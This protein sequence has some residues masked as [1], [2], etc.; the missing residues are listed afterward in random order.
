[1]RAAVA[2]VPGR[3]RLM[4]RACLLAAATVA[5][6]AL[7]GCG[8]EERASAPPGTDLTIVLLPGGRDKPGRQ[9]WTLRCDPP[10]GSLPDPGAACDALAAAA[11][12]FAPV[13]PDTVCT[14]IFGGYQILDV[15]G[16]FR[17]K[18]IRATFSRTDGCQIDRF[19]R[20]A[21]ALGLRDAARSS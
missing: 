6:L 2:A 14:Q 5:T 9:A 12:P 11:D 20:I 8:D 10:A 7:G 3:T 4:L 17:G 1:M 18:A 13:P 15:T 16:T 19:D 21:L